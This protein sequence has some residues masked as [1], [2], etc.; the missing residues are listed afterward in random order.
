MHDRGA[1]T[2]VRVLITSSRG[3]DH[4]LRDPIMCIRGVIPP[5]REDSTSENAWTPA[6]RAQRG[7]GSQFRQR[8]P[9]SQVT[10]AP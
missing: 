3:P 5:V 4:S 10:P 7:P 1:I 2:P 6:S 9:G 8:V